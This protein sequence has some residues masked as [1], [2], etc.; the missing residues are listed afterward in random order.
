MHLRHRGTSAAPLALLAALL[1]VAPSGHAASPDAG[2][3][4]TGYA[5][6][7]VR[8]VDLA[9]R[10]KVGW[11]SFGVIWWRYET[12]PGSYRRLGH[13]DRERWAQLGA[14][15]A[16]AKA[17][18]LK[19][20]VTFF[21]PPPWARASDDE[22]AGPAADRVDDFARFVD[23]VVRTYGGD[24][25]AYATWNEPNI[26]LFWRDPDPNA[27]A[28]LHRAAASRI[29]AG[30]PSASIVL[31]P[32]AGNA[33]NALGFTSSVYANGVRRS[34]DRLG[35]N[36]YPAT[37]PWVR[38]DAATLD[39]VRLLGPLLRRVDPG[40]RVWIGEVGWSTCACGNEAFNVVSPPVQA[41]YLLSALSYTRRYLR[42]LVDRMSVYSLAD[43]PN[44]TAWPE[45]HGLVRFDFRPKPA[46][47]AL[48][49]ARAALSGPRVRWR[50]NASGPGGAVRGLRLVPRRGVIRV[51]ARL[52]LP[53]SGRVRVFGYWR[54]R[55][56]PLASE[57]IRSGRVSLPIEDRGFRAIR[58]MVRGPRS[59]WVTAQMP[60]PS[61]PRISTAARA[62]L[63]T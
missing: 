13:P 61:A 40:R 39:S 56:R 5:T 34:V 53:S 23:D 48:A 51:S 7:V 3:V 55:W 36:V 57:R 44:E 24:I 9:S 11:I 14:E 10:L 37:A 2:V 18:G 38:G 1:W 8:Q 33:P 19:V 35:W 26:D 28:R 12:T 4:V 58:V 15:L 43:G 46:F 41:D 6:P 47:R 52:T 45:N 21:R 62:R 59:G 32:F 16:A 49:G 60:V 29:R 17:H 20:S 25:D 63:R 50:R 30:D 42:G 31:G 54:G 22:R 27:Y